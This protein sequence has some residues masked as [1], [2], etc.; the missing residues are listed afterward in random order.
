MKN[1]I[2]DSILNESYIEYI[3]SSGLR[4]YLMK[5]SGYSTSHAVFGTA[6]GSVDTKFSRN[7]G[8]IISV[9]EGI[10][11]FLEHKLFESEELDAFQLFSKTGAYANAYTSFDRTCY[12]FSCS[13]NLKEN[14]E[15]LLNFVQSPYFTKETVEKEQ[16]I[17]GQEI[18]MYEDSPDWRVMFNLFKAL[19]HNHPAKIEIAGTKESIS[20]IDDKLLYECYNTFYNLS[21]MFFCLVGDFD[22]DEIL[23]IIVK[24]LKPH[25]KVEFVR[26]NHNEPEEIVKPYIEQKLTVSKPQFMMGFKDKADSDYIPLKRRISMDILLETVFGSSAKFYNNLLEEGLINKSF[27]FEYFTSRGIAAVL[28]GGESD[29]PEV[30][31]F[32]IMEEI[33]RVKKEGIDPE[34]FEDIRR[35]EYGGS[36]T[37]F[38]NIQGISSL[39]V[40]CAVTGDKLFD[41]FNVLRNLELEDIVEC[42]EVFGTKNSALSVIK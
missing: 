16:G 12:L 24:N 14:L 8:E 17:I 25:Q 5:K 22:E 18:V 38:D 15:I 36:V 34:L 30:V 33:E 31:Q 41:E 19:Y 21:N 11:H 1:K 32:R 23:E 39:L 28:I 29:N 20:H 6:Y 3:H 26:G 27:G 42:L 37:A 7:G 40:D 2:I 13:S 10:A 9:P 4:I 35:S